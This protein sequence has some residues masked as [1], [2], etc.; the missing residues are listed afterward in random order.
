M[1]TLTVRNV[2]QI[3]DIPILYAISMTCW[4]TK[5]YSNLRYNSAWAVLFLY[6]WRNCFSEIGES[7][8]QS[9][10]DEADGIP[11]PF[12]KEALL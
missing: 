5:G 3:D 11:N 6:P 9:D 1:R 2:A 12:A 7:V 10:Q 8:R 4:R